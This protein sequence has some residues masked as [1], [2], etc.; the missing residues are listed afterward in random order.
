MRR[1]EPYRRL[2]VRGLWLLRQ[3]SFPVDHDLLA[4]RI[5]ESTEHDLLAHV[6][7]ASGERSLAMQDFLGAAFGKR[8]RFG[9]PLSTRVGVLVWAGEMFCWSCGAETGIVTRA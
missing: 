8:R 4:T 3:G 6:P 7:A 2:G 5:S 9:I 1:Q